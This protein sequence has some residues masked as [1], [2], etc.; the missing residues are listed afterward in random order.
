MKGL[1]EHSLFLRQKM[2]CDKVKESKVATP[3]YNLALKDSRK[4]SSFFFS[5]PSF[6]TYHGQGHDDG[7]R[8]THGRG[9]EVSDFFAK[10]AVAWLVSCHGYTNDNMNV[11]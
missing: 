9:H 1:T 8:L 11:A 10:L 5:Y 2:S 4:I 3:L 7:H 6:G